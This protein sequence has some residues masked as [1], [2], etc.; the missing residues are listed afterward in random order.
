MP[1]AGSYRLRWLM[2]HTDPITAR[3]P[4][5]QMGS[6]HLGKRVWV[7]IDYL[8]PKRRAQLVAINTVNGESAEPIVF[9]DEAYGARDLEISRNNSRYFQGEALSRP[10]QTF[11]VELRSMK[12][13][14]R[15]TA[16]ANVVTFD[17]SNRA[18]YYELQSQF[19]AAPFDPELRGSNT[20]SFGW[21]PENDARSVYPGPSP[22]IPDGEETTLFRFSRGESSTEVRLRFR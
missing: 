15:D 3:V 22:A 7:Q 4:G 13:C 21:G 5:I 18:F 6:G 8:G 2:D 19:Y 10:R 20:T 11:V 1:A 9:Y 17:S 12:G 14:D 16:L